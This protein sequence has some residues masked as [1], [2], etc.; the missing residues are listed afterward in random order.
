MIL[1]LPVNWK[2]LAAA[3]RVFSFGMVKVLPKRHGL[4]VYCDFLDLRKGSLQDSHR[5]YPDAEESPG[6]NVME[7]NGKRQLW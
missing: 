1:P 7:L 6:A 2:R 3:R 4:P 5:L